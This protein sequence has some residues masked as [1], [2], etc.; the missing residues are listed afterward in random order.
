MLLSIISPKKVIL[1]HI[2]LYLFNILLETIKRYSNRY[3]NNSSV[4]ECDF[5]IV[6]LFIDIVNKPHY[7][8][9]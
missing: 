2:V 5:T 3:L 9:Y 7:R 8:A 4:K 1:I 6:I